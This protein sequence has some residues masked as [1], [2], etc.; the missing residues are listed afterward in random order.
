MEISQKESE[1]PAPPAYLSALRLLVPVAVCLLLAAWLQ[2]PDGR[3]RVTLLDTP[4]D[5]I[6]LQL[7]DG[8]FA[9][10][11]GGSDPARLALLLGREMPFWRRDLAAV[12][13]TS[14]DGRRLPGQVAALARY[15]PD[16]ALAPS[17]LPRGGVGGEWRRLVAEL[18]VP[19]RE[20]R[21]GMRL[22]LGGATL[23]VLA[24]APG[25][26]GGAVILVRYGTARVLLH[27][28]GPAGDAA[29]AQLAGPPLSMLVYPWQRELD[30]PAP[31]L[32]P[33]SI[34]FSAAYEA[35]EPALLS[36]VDRR[37]ASPNIYH[38]ANDGGISLVS[39]GRRA[40]VET[41]K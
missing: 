9:L 32:G 5:A 15:R 28:G 30:T 36:Y 25:D 21:P 1:R 18:D 39:D 3:L 40:W 35:E 10:I 29:V 12:L 7:P 38:P 13:L 26:T 2:R 34:A 37:R 6:L 23:Q 20:L 19:A 33:R 14:P 4:G 31:A 24:V 11:D 22:G 8:R 27:T 17:G 41:E 16:L